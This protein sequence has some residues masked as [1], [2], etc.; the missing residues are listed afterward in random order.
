MLVMKSFKYKLKPT[1]KQANILNRWLGTCRYIYN[2]ALEYK[3]YLFEHKCISISKFDL[4]KELP[5]MKKVEGFEWI[6]E[7]P[8]QTLQA[9][10]ERLDN[11][12]QRFFKLGVGFPKFAKKDNYKSFQLKQKVRIYGN[13]FK[14]PKIGLVKFFNSREVEGKIKIATVS[15]EADG[16]YISVSFEGEVEKLPK[17]DKEVGLDL[18]VKNFAY[19]S[20][21]GVIENPRYYRKYQNEL[22]VLQRSKARKVKGSR[23]WNKVKNQISRLHQKIVNVRR[24][25]LQKE[26]TKLLN[27]NQV[28]VVE[29]LQIK[30]LVRRPKPIISEKK[31]NSSPFTYAHNGAKRKSG[32]NKSILDAGWGMFCNMLDNK[33]NWYGRTFAKVAPQYTSMDCST[34][35][36]TYRA[37]SMPLS[38]RE[39]ECP[40]CGALHERD[41]NAS[42]NIL[43]KW[44]AGGSPEAKRES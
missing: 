44:R 20:D 15:K 5:E 6:G 23:A 4:I 32:L 40:E 41:H 9:V 29:N 28:V 26:S 3:K 33:A 42:K 21:G 27:E 36:C 16:W 1:K 14:L 39:W 35:G 11:A 30:N 17:T 7:V 25:F 18:G 12:Y 13:S 8:S 38:I 34:E 10:M 19:T 2:L 37:E 31:G 22:R 43:N 24:D